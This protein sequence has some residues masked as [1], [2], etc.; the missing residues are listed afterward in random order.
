MDENN[1]KQVAEKLLKYSGKIKGEIFL[2]HFRYIKHVKGEKGL[3]EIEEKMS[4]LGSSMKFEEILASDWYKEGE[5]ALF[6]LVTKEVFNWTDEDIY[7]MGRAAPK[8]SFLMKVLMQHFVSLDYAF[9]QASKN[10]DKHFDF[11]SLHPVEF[12]KKEGYLVLHIKDFKS[13]KISC[14][15]HSGYFRGIAELVMGKN[16]SSEETKC[17]HD[18]DDYC[19]HVIRWK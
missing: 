19:E 9:D 1:L 18:G 6:L 14:V 4:S 17:I 7:E 16:V 11:G 13:D 8:F 10:W 12:N 2:T 15:F 5:S 3:K